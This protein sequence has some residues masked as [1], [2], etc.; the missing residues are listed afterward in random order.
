MKFTLP[1]EQI[2]LDWKR[3][4]VFWSGAV[5]VGVVAILLAIASEQANLQFHKLVAISPYLPLIV[6]PLG[7]VLVVVLTRKVFPGSQGSGIPQT[8]AALDPKETYKVRDQVL[9]LRVAVGKLGLTV[10]GLFVGSSVGREG[11]TVQIGAAIMHSLGKYARFP[12]HD[13][14]KGL[15]LAGGAAGVAAAFNTP[16][17]GIVFAIEEMS[18]SFEEHN[19]STILM[20]VII[21]GITLLALLGNYSYFGRT[22]ET[23]AFGREWD[24]VILCGIAGGLL[25]GAFSRALI[26]FNKGLTGQMGVWMRAKPIAFAAVCGVLLALI[27]LASDN[28]TYGS[29]Y[30]EAKS[31]IDGSAVLPESY[32]LLKM[33]A[34]VVSYLSGI[35]G[36][37]MAPTLS[38]GAGFGANIAHFFTSVPM[39]AAIILG[40]V[41]YFAGVTQAPIT[42]FVIVM[43][44]TGNHD[45][46]LPLMAAA[47][48]AKICSRLVCPTPLFHTLAKDFLQ[49]VAH[50]PNQA[51]V[52]T[53]NS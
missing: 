47:F 28:T 20:T 8:I 35:P 14:E 9:S 46:L 12:R 34:T 37:I 16:L 50:P 24:V 17:A 30:I 4:L 49:K 41:A 38:A 42:A 22:S 32:G 31:L 29:G 13:L 3:R 6:T 2:I 21:A 43:E 33:A 10:M 36:G 27:G 52:K 7:L 53:T 23:L 15:I 48:I 40:M 25:G 44:M 1:D 18:R 11:P 51:E 26:E 5:A 39:G 19:S 45:M